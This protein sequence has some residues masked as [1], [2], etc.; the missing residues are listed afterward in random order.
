MRVR[1]RVRVGAFHRGIGFHIPRGLFGHQDLCNVC[2]LNKILFEPP[3]ICCG[4]C[5]NKI[6]RGNQMYV[7]PD[8]PGEAADSSGD[9][10]RQDRPMSMTGDFSVL[11]GSL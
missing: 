5:Y 9:K 4:Y 11:P 6:K 7:V 1:A 2:G 10:V 3:M 8:K